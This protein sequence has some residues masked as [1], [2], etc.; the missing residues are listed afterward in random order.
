MKK[1]VVIIGIIALTFLGLASEAFCQGRSGG[2]YRG[3]GGY[4][5]YHGGGYH[6]GPYH[7]GPYYGGGRYYY[8]GGSSVFFGFGFPFYGYYPS[9]Y[10]YYYP[11]GYPYSYPYA[12]PYPYT[13][14]YYSSTYDQ[15]TMYIEPEQPSYWYYCQDPKGYYPY[16]TSCPS[17]WAKVTPAPP[18]PGEEGV[19][20]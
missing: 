15:P 16:V 7:G 4:G 19:A 11:Y 12:Y 13:Y 3:G 1:V 6:G 10:P 20:R 9:G 17:G 18:P 5:G 8:G 14:P 2:G